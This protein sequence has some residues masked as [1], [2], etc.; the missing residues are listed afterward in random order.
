MIM[1]NLR[2]FKERGKAFRHLLGKKQLATFAA[3]LCLMAMMPLTARAQSVGTQKETI[4]N[5]VGRQATIRQ[6]STLYVGEV[7]LD[8]Q[9]SFY[10]LYSGD[11]T[12]RSTVF[13]AVKD[14]LSN[15]ENGQY[16]GLVPSLV[17]ATSDVGIAVCSN[18]DYEP[19]MNSDWMSAE[20]AGL[21]C[22]PD[23][24]VVSSSSED[25]YAT[26]PGFVSTCAAFVATE[27]GEEVTIVDEVGED[28]EISGILGKLSTTNY[29]EET[30]QMI[31]GHLV[32]VIS[33]T[34]YYDCESITVI[35]TRAELRS[36]ISTVA[37][38]I[39]H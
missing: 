22:L 34:I 16:R 21:A 29:D 2:I 9:Q 18:P 36:L 37:L 1:K 32:K 38:I 11:I 35:Y 26:N 27:Y 10:Y 6:Y 25:L 31:N 20:N 5:V 19:M 39:K 3:I 33:R 15:F 4:V 12:Q 14:C 17:G 30:Y 13:G 8:G 24:T 28:V 7:L 23:A